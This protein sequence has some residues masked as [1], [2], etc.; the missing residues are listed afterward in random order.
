MFNGNA[1]VVLYHQFCQH[2]TI[3]K[4]NL[5]AEKIPDILI[6]SGGKF[7]GRDEKP[8]LCLLTLQCSDEFL[9]FGF[10]DSQVRGPLF[11][12]YIN[13]AE[14]KLIFLDDAVNTAVVGLLRLLFRLLQAHC[15]I[16]F[17]TAILQQ[18]FQIPKETV[19]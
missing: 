5:C 9:N 19:S 8:L 11:S 15:R 3:Y 12:L 2:F 17:S 16:P 14:S 6:R 13:V 4:N 18:A 10:A 7:C 1:D